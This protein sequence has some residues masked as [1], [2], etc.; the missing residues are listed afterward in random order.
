MMAFAFVLAI[1]V[2]GFASDSSSVSN[3]RTENLVVSNASATSASNSAKAKK[4]H[5]KAHKK[6]SAK[7]AKK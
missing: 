4:A 2:S 1:A 7:K 3:T 5:H 6:G